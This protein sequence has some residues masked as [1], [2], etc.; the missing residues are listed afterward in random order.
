MGGCGGN[1]LADFFA[2]GFAL[3]PA[4]FSI[5]SCVDLES[6]PDGITPGLPSPEHPE[7]NISINTL[8][9]AEN[10]RR[11]NSHLLKHSVEYS[12]N[13]SDAVKLSDTYWPVNSLDEEFENFL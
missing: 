7:I 4:G 2:E 12:L 6:A 13:R 8:K 5:A 9:H 1:E 10:L 11:F 3:T